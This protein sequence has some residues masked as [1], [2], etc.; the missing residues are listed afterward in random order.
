MFYQLLFGSD[1][2]LKSELQLPADPLSEPNLFFHSNQNAHY[3]H[4]TASHHFNQLLSAFYTLGFKDP[5]TKTLL[6]ILASIYH[7]GNAG[8]IPT[9]ANSRHGQFNYPNEAHKAA[10]LIG[11]SFQQLND[12]IFCNLPSVQNQ[13]HTKYGHLSNNGSARVSPTDANS[14]SNLTPLECLEGFCLGMYQE[15][16]N[17]LT[18]L[19][20]RSFKNTST[21][22]FHHQ[23]SISNS[24]LIVDPPGFQYQQTPATALSTYSDLMCN[25]LSERL[26]L[27][28]YQINFINPIEKCAQEGLDVD[29]VEHIP[30]SPSQLV[31]WFDKPVAPAILNRTV[32]TIQVNGHLKAPV[33]NNNCGLL[34]LLEDQM[35]SGQKSAGV[36]MRKLIV[37]DQK[38]NFI[39]IKSDHEGD[40]ETR[41]FTIHHQF[42]QFP[43]E[44]DV[45]KWLEEYCKEYVTQ[46][47]ALVVLHES[48]KDAILS[49]FR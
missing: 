4:Q 34:W 26:Q 29:L 14:V 22:N 17:F 12:N 20:N 48:K 19:I 37:S 39:S 43:V 38:Q 6:S 32:N 30:E 3:L 11:V 21:V 41:S 42:G 28:F 1:P 23:Q 7:L 46:S 35:A 5:E 25:Y 27:M 49:S 8:A 24:M 33:N 36:F 18:N 10:N 9:T 15:A 16:L 31:N 47:N 2:K 45:S 13:P 40:K 44:Y